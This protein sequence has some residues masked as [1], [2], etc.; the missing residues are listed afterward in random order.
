MVKTSQ[1]EDR[2]LFRITSDSRA[3]GGRE[4]MPVF[5]Y[6]EMFHV[7]LRIIFPSCTNASFT[8][9]GPWLCLYLCFVLKELLWKRIRWRQEVFFLCFI[10]LY[11]TLVDHKKLTQTEICASALHRKMC[12][13]KRLEPPDLIPYKVKTDDWQ[14]QMTLTN[15]DFEPAESEA[16][17]GWLNLYLRI[18][19][20]IIFIWWNE[21]SFLNCYWVKMWEPAKFLAQ[22]VLKDQ[23]SSKED[24]FSV[25][26]TKLNVAHISGF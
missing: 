18:G 8:C 2:C 7:N 22:R 12:L 13:S 24:L 11:R 1:L 23:I 21:Y 9:S 15:S 19:W 10:C 6:L 14:R 26:R 25:T 17:H 5:L 3:G 20:N 16:E 4:S